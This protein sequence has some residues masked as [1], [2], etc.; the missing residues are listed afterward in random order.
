L[1][2]ILHIG[3]NGQTR[4]L[5]QTV[6]EWREQVANGVTNGYYR[7]HANE[8]GVASGARASRISSVGFPYGLNVLMTG[9][10][11]DSLNA[12]YVI[13]Y[14]D[15]ANPFKHIYNPGHDNLGY[16]GELLP[17]G[18]ESYTLTNTVSL[19]L[20]QPPEL[21]ANATFWNPGEEIEGHYTHTINGLRLE[22]V[23]AEGHFKLRRVNR[24]GVLE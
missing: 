11:Q 12:P 2:V 17:E 18:A 1:R 9:S 21:G 6:M 3:T 7:L 4:L 13:G 14:N 8:K 10:L 16:S 15:P 20:D 22:P 19:V 23:R 24:T 5:Q